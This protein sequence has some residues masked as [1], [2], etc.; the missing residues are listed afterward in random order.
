M[1]DIIGT[2]GPEFPP[3]T[4][5]EF[6]DVTF[7]C[8]LDVSRHLTSDIHT[9]I[10]DSFL[11][12][13][14]QK[15]DRTA[16]K[17]APKNIT[18]VLQLLKIK[19]IKDIEHLADRN[20]FKITNDTQASLSSELARY[21]LKTFLNHSTKDLPPE[22]R[23]ELAEAANGHDDESSKADD[24]PTAAPS[25]PAPTPAAPMSSPLVRVEVSSA[26][27]TAP[28]KT[29]PLRENPRP[30]KQTPPAQNR[31]QPEAFPALART[32]PGPGQIPPARPKPTGS[33]SL[34]GS[35]RPTSAPRLD[36]A[37]NRNQAGQPLTA[38]SRVPPAAAPRQSFSPL[39]PAQA[40][41]RP[42][43]PPAAT[44]PPKPA[45]QQ[46]QQPNRGP[47]PKKDSN[48]IPKLAIIKIEPKN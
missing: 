20:Y 5:C 34:L 36:L 43:Q 15:E 29:P 11:S 40:P 12:N 44:A 46:Q 18:Q 24:V 10:R 45:G 23:Q 28:K 38:A 37:A 16:R 30:S 48:Y 25:A 9:R 41:P 14:S 31:A 21:L 22:V 27:K 42:D 39:R 7:K 8:D 47:Q 17:Q 2:K 32:T 33:V 4:K 35:T 13:Y 6:C 3:M 1:T 19:S 26:S